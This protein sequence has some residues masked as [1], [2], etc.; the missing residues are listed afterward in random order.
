MTWLH[1]CFLPFFRFHYRAPRG[2]IT[3]EVLPVQYGLLV[4]VVFMLGNR[5]G[6]RVFAPMAYKAIFA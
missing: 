3:H 2:K 5:V 1:S 4:V 6:R